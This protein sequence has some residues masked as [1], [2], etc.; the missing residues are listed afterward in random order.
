M[1]MLKEIV[2]IAL[3]FAAGKL[4]EA[5]SGFPAPLGS[6]ILLTLLLLSGVLK[7]ELFRGG[8]SDLILKNM[9]FFF[10]PPGIRV[11]DSLHILEGAVVKL[12]LIMLI[13]NVLVMGVTGTVVQFVLKKSEPETYDV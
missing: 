5:A 10:L 11:L 7:E 13:S 1:K 9:S 8:L 3:L 12:V 4:L 2:V 6:M